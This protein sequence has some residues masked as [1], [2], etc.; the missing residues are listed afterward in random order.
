MHWVG[1]FRVVRDDASEFPRRATTARP[2]AYE[3][4]MPR[5]ARWFAVLQPV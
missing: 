3:G 2:L 5:A 1:F 4:G